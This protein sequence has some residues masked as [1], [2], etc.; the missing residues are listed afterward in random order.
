M[1]KLKWR[2]R[3]AIWA[4][5]NPYV[6]TFLHFDMLREGKTRLSGGQQSRSAWCAQ[7]WADRLTS[8]RMPMARENVKVLS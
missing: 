4:F 5:R 7:T 6:L 2:I 1:N 8:A 3:M